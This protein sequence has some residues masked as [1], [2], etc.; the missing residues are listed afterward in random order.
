[1]EFLYFVFCF[2]GPSNLT[3]ELFLLYLL[4]PNISL[5]HFLLLS[6]PFLL[7]TFLI[8]RLCRFLP[9]L[10]PTYFQTAIFVLSNADEFPFVPRS[11]YSSY[12]FLFV[13][14]LL[15]SISEEGHGMIVGVFF[16][17]LLFIVDFEDFVVDFVHSV[18]CRFDYLFF[19]LNMI[20]SH[21]FLHLF[22]II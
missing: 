7:Y 4:P 20:C 8:H 14:H 17:F 6:H 18:D 16:L 5:F 21:K 15:G 3:L 1:M 9:F 22:S 19:I 13:L 10:F 11:V 12:F 2:D